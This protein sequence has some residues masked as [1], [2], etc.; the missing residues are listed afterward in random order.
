LIDDVLIPSEVNDTHDPHKT[1]CLVHP[2]PDVV[3]ERV[4]G[5]TPQIVVVNGKQVRVVFEL[6]QVVA[7]LLPQALALLWGFCLVPVKS[8]IYVLLG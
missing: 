3:W 8:V 6:V 4:H 5:P 2:V 7:D 1:V